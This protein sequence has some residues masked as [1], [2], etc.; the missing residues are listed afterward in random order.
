MTPT[1][2]QVLRAIAKDQPV[3]RFDSLN[4]KWVRAT[5]KEVCT[6]LA[7]GEL[8]NLRVAIPTVRV[9][10]MTC[11]LPAESLVSKAKHSSIGTCVVA[12]Q[13]GSDITNYIFRS[14]DDASRFYCGI[15]RLTQG[16][17]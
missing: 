15:Y 8:S 10:G 12:V 9:G 14:A 3:E 1:T 17:T 16:L 2:A 11:A 6:I 5:A 13:C 4:T 7:E